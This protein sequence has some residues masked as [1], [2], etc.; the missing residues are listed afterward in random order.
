M[1]MPFSKKL[2]GV[3]SPGIFR[4]NSKIDEESVPK[5]G[6]QGQ[7]GIARLMACE[8]GGTHHFS[9]VWENVMFVAGGAFQLRALLFWEF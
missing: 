2:K 8:F 7:F 9:Q 3:A 1:K 5:R 6:N 4:K